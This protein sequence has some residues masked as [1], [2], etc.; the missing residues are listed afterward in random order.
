[1]TGKNRNFATE[2]PR[3]S[4]RPEIKCSMEHLDSPEAPEDWGESD[5]QEDDGCCAGARPKT[6]LPRTP[7]PVGPPPGLH[8][9]RSLII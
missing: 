8:A 2:N 9:G 7:K 5:Y 6:M 1:M 3:S 4:F